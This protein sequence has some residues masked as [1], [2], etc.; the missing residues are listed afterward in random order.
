MI[1][2]APAAE[3]ATF[4]EKV[5]EPGRRFL[6]KKPQP[7]TKEWA[8][9]ACWTCC[10]SDLMR[11]YHCI[12][13]YSC[14]RIAPDTG[15]PSVDHFVPKSESPQDAYEWLNYRL[16]AARL[17]TRKGRRKVLDPF[18]IQPGTFAIHFPSL[19]V[20]PGPACQDEPELA[21][22]VRESCRILGL[23]DETTC[24]ANRQEYVW[25][26]CAEQMKF[27]MLQ[28][29]APFLAGEMENAGLAD[30]QAMRAKMRWP[31]ERGER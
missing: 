7:S 16:A 4:H 3:P 22:Q 27:Q 31:F 24:I 1:P 13:A 19:Q 15:A 8:R 26:Y 2:V 30:L 6:A 12:C 23:N 11:S 20:I 18:T 9:N 29:H 21:N 25:M 14:H 17:N 28:E 5:R 10:I